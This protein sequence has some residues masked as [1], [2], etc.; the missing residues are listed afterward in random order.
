M[1]KRLD[2]RAFLRTLGGSTVAGALAACDSSSQGSTGTANPA[3][4]AVD[5]GGEGHGFGRGWLNV[6]Y[7]ADVHRAGGIGMSQV[8]PGIP[9]ALQPGKQHAEYMAQPVVRTDLEATDVEVRA[10]LRAQ[11][12]VEAGVIARA[13]FDQA[14]ACLVTGDSLLLCRYDIMDRT[15]LKRAPLHGAGGWINVVLEAKGS[16][17]TGT[18]EKGPRTLARIQVDD[19]SAP[20]GAGLGGTL[21]NPASVTGGGKAEFRA[22]TMTSP[23]AS[24]PSPKLLYAFSGAVVPAGTGY[25]A[26][27]TARTVVPDKIAF[28]VADNEAFSG[29]VSVDPADPAGK[30]GSVHAELSGLKGATRYY[31]RPVLVDGSRREPGPTYTLRTPPKTGD[32]AKIVFASCTSGRVTRLPSF[33]LASKLEPELYIHAGDWGYADLTSVKHSADHFHARWLRILRAPE[34]G[35]MLRNTPLLMWQDDHDY[36]ADNG[37]RKTIK[38]YAVWSWDEMHANPSERWFDVRW[39]DLHLWCVDCRAYA[40]DPALPDGPGKTRIGFEQKR[41]L[42]DGLKASDAPVRIIAPGMAFANKTDEDPGWQSVYTWERD[43]LLRF[44]SQIPATVFV[45]S[46]D[47]HGQRL[48]HHFE[49]GELY[50]ITSSGT[51]FKAGGQGNNDPAHTLVNISGKGGIGLVELDPASRGRKVTVSTRQ[52]TDGKVFFSKSFEVSDVPAAKRPGTA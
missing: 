13:S 4:V 19:P 21:V 39:G 10:S 34:V 24:P 3:H 51:D 28:E 43:Q 7:E 27:V 6:R 35:R 17:L 36:A 44:F 23:D 15:I 5:F 1:T 37:W 22:Y 9:K 14:Y 8:P 12:P 47:S 29:A 45:L 26:R 30:L 50:E 2:R 38:P 49:F 33:D 40:N 18:V 41:W 11:G 32:A 42:M 20:L 25:R 46:G 52:N 31:W 48:I 16:T